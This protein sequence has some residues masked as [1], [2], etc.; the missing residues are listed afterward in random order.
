M[1][2]GSLHGPSQIYAGGGSSIIDKSM[3]DILPGVVVQIM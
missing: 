2:Y 1:I 3:V